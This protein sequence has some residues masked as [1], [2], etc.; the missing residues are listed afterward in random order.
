M[1]NTPTLI[2]SPAPVT[3]RGSGRPKRWLVT[4]GKC[5][6][7]SILL[8]WLLKDTSVHDITKAVHMS[9]IPMILL[10]FSLHFVGCFLS[11]IRWRVLLL[12]QHIDIPLPFLFKSYMVAIF[13]NNLLPSTIGGD[14][15]RIHDTC[16]MGND[17]G[18]AVAAVFVDRLL[19]IFVLM[20]FVL[21][22]LLISREFKFFSS[23]IYVCITIS[24]ISLLILIIFFLIFNKRILHYFRNNCSSIIE[25]MINLKK[26]KKNIATSILLSI[27]LQINVVLYYFLISSSLSID[28]SVSEFF[29]IVPFAVFSMMIPISINGVGIRENIFVF[30]MS[31][32]QVHKN[33]SIAMAW[34]DYGMIVMLG[35]IGG[36]VYIIRK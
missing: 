8:L 24:I 36:I 7:S 29:F 10:A 26:H 27:G 22:S 3:Q 15:V 23:Y 6:I 20:S 9:Y 18:G 35:I 5:A 16:R 11:V 28:I 33:I 31:I 30:M 34:I 21:L 13:F 25:I 12:A 19:G 14:V 2:E 4:V 17:R 32:Y 1:H